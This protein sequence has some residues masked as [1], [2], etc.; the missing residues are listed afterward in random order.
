MSI[1]KAPSPNLLGAF[2]E[3]TKE[4]DKGEIRLGEFLTWLQKK[5]KEREKD[6]HFWY[7]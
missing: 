1:R 2:E 3:F 6:K 7:K 5:T 4:T